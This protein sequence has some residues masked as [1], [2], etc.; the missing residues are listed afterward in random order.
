[1]SEQ[2]LDNQDWTPVV[3]RG[4]STAKTATPSKLSQESITNINNFKKL[5]NLD[6][7]CTFKKLSSESRQ[8]LIQARTAKNFKQDDLARAL[9]MPSNTY[10]AIENGKNV[11]TQQ[12]LNKINNYLKTSLKLQ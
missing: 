1:M 5:E 6:G 11:P 4:K 2:E 12:E 3:I 9:N 8:T 10:K 7:P